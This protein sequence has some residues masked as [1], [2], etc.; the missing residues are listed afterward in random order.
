MESTVEL[1]EILIN[2]LC[3]TTDISVLERIKKILLPANKVT[4]KKNEVLAFSPELRAA[5]DRSLVQADNG[6]LISQ[7]ELDKEVERWLAE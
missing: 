6:E 3:R 7:E 4:R 5:I 2:E 1:K